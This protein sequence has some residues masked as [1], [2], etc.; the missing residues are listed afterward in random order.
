MVPSVNELRARFAEAST[1]LSRTRFGRFTA[2]VRQEPILIGGPPGC[3][4]TELAKA[5]PF[6]LD[7]KMERL[8][9]YRGCRAD[10][11]PDSKKT[12]KKA[13]GH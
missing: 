7:T 8:E 1:S 2:G 13:P 11:L 3:N 6:A 9:C 5:V 10:L 12:A 4:K